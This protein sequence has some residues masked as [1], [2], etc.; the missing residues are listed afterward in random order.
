MTEPITL[1]SISGAFFLAFLV[2]RNS[3][4]TEA[5]SEIESKKFIKMS[6]FN[7]LIDHENGIEIND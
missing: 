5:I 6:K 4:K 3:E 7:K 2:K 1:L